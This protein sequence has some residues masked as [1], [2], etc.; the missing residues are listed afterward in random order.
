MKRFLP[1]LCLASAMIFALPAGAVATPNTG[2]NSSTV[3][4]IMGGLLILSLATIVGC[5]I[6]N[7]RR[8]KK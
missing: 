3:L 2:D 6:W 8:R 5:L 4:A 1:L 7:A